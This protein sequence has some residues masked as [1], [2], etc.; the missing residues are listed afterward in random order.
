MTPANEVNPSV[1][2]ELAALLTRALAKNPADRY[3]TA[4]EFSAALETWLGTSGQVVG[5]TELSGVMRGLFGAEADVDP[6]AS[7][8][9]ATVVAQRPAAR[10]GFVAAMRGL[11]VFLLGAGAW[12][13]LR[14]SPTPMAPPPPPTIVEAKAPPPLP[15]GKPG[16]VNFRVK[17]WGEIWLDGVKLGVTPN[18]QVERPPGHYTF[19]VKNPAWPS[20]EL[21]VQVLPE[22]EVSVKV[23]LTQV[24]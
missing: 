13:V 21:S 17:P 8:Q 18:V 4:A 22:S 9:L 12:F 1:P 7:D 3:Q 16:K 23:D 5:E 15:T 11:T 14:P 24:Q 6:A 10:R 2:V 19:T 20:Q